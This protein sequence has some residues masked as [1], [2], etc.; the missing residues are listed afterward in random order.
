MF[1]PSL[2]P[3]YALLF[4][5]A[6]QCM[7]LQPEIVDYTDCNFHHTLFYAVHS[8]KV[9]EYLTYLTI[10]YSGVVMLSYVL[11][12]RQQNRVQSVSSEVVG[13]KSEIHQEVQL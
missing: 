5:T 3:Q 1:Q 2:P 12:L 7:Q 9:C 11:N 6:M 4:V 13:G 8:C 10:L